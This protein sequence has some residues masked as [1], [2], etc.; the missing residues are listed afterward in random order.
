MI[1]TRIRLPC[2]ADCCVTH[3]QVIGLRANGEY[4][5]LDFNKVN[6]DIHVAWDVLPRLH[7][8]PVTFMQRALYLLESSPTLLESERLLAERLVERLYH[9][10][11]RM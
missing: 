10:F 2:L 7:E 11:K 8:S 1:K 5:L 6:P 4:E 9:T 3:R